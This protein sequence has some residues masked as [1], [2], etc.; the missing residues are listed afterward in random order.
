MIL[1]ERDSGRV[2]FRV[3]HRLNLDLPIILVERSKAKV[4]D[5]QSYLNSS[6]S[7]FSGGET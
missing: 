5:E 7:S 4:G 2:A 3:F 6:F 1:T